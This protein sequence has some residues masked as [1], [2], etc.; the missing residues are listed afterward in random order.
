[1]KTLLLSLSF[2]IA[3]ITIIHAQKKQFNLTVKIAGLK[4]DKGSLIVGLYNQ[5]ELFL[6]KHYRGVYSKIKN[7][8][9]VVVF[10]DIPKGEYA[11]SFIHDKNNNNKMDTNFLGIP[12]EEYGCSN[13]AVGFMGPPKYKDAKFILESN[14]NISITIN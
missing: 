9:S 4:S 8:K 14:K 13:N 12:K 6:K 11:I 10:K 1:M 5:K 2:F 3:S 7:Q